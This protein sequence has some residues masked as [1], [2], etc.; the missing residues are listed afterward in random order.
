MRHTIAQY[1]LLLMVLFHSALPAVSM[2]YNFRIAQVTKQPLS[3]NA[4]H[5]N[6]TAIALPFDQFL[7]KHTHV[8]Q[9]YAG[10]LG[11]FIYDFKPW[12]FRTDF[13]ASHIQEKLYDTTTYSGA[14]ADDILFTVGRN[15]KVHNKAVIT[16]SGLF[17]V[18]T[19]KL[20]TL[21]HATFGYSQV[22]IGAQLDGSYDLPHASAII[23]GV[24][25][26][27]FVPRT[28]Y[29]DSCQ[30]YK[31]T[32]G[33][34]ADILLSYK[35]NWDPHGI[36]LGF[37]ERFQFGAHISPTLADIVKR[38]NYI[39]SNFYAIYKYK[40][41]I[42]TIP[43]RFLFNISYGFDTSPKKYGNKYIVTFWGSWSVNF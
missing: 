27:Y 17:G 36:E 14:Q 19:H 42:R 15:F 39:R 20:L 8:R 40:F 25:Y 16:L 6:F 2:V 13:A 28:A 29:D 21:Q 30:K 5:R 43:N 7:K 32:I 34:I 41:L 37:T 4:D 24:R 10:A 31:F 35:K 33:N 22:G 26:I 23:Y 11:S 18:P 12:Y 3:E 1:L 9:N 38:T